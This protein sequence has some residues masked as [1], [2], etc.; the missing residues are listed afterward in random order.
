MNAKDP[1][2]IEDTIQLTKPDNIE[3]ILNEAEKIKSEDDLIDKLDNT[4]RVILDYQ[5]P[6]HKREEYE[7]MIDNLIDNDDVRATYEEDKGYVRT[8]YKKAGYSILSIL[9][10]TITIAIGI[11]IAI[12][13]IK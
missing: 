8:R 4:A 1:M 12:I 11:I 9:I 10:S 2:K 6:E 3:G 5:S 13:C 7:N